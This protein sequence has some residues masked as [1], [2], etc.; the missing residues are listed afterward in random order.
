MINHLCKFTKKVLGEEEYKSIRWAKFGRFYTKPGSVKFWEA[1]SKDP[2]YIDYR[3]LTFPQR[4]M[5]KAMENQEDRLKLYRK[6]CERN[7]RNNV[8][9]RKGK[10]HDDRHKI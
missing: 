10:N 4:T 9:V 6:F 5:V 2:D 7:S 1:L 8:L 3:K